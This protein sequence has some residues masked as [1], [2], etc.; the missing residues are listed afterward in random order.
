MS[1][2]PIKEK[3]VYLVHCVDTEGPLYESIFE[4]FERIRLTFNIKL[5][6]SIEMLKRLQR[7]EILL[8]NGL[9]EDIA[10]FISP[11]RFNYLSTWDQIQPVLDELLS[12]SFRNRQL[13]SSGNGWVYTWFCM[14]HVGFSGYNPRRRDAGYHNIFDYYLDLYKG[15][16]LGKDSVQWHYHPVSFSGDFHRLGT[17]FLGSSNIFQ[18]L[19]RKIIDRCW[20]PSAFRPGFHVERPDSNWFLEQWIPFDYGNQATSESYAGQPDMAEGRYGDWRRA[21]SDWRIYHPSQDDYQKEG[22]SRRWIA[23]CLNMEAR[24]RT[25]QLKDF[26]NGFERANSGMPTLISYCN[27]DFR[28]MRGEIEKIRGMIREASKEFPDV[29]YHFINAVDGMRSTLGLTPMQPKMEI[30]VEKTRTGSQRVVVN[31]KGEVFGPQPFLALRTRS[32]QYHWDN[33]DFQDSRCWTYTFDHETFQYSALSHFGIATT[34]SYGTT[35]V[36]VKNTETEEVQLK[37]Y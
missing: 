30:V 33:F 28:D 9:S 4:T 25:I 18:I 2:N 36:F 10:N 16:G 22:N 35:E 14:D 11:E 24:I 13:D 29:K 12:D 20:F 6:P 17:Q 1:T 5:D 7:R 32:G 21:P 34:S 26:C 3:V 8:P 31:C 27:H 15:L 19:A 37:S 23:R